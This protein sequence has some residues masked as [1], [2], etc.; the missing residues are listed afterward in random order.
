MYMYMDNWNLCSIFLLFSEIGDRE[1]RIEVVKELVDQLP[2]INRRILLMLI[3][4]LHRLL[5]TC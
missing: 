5:C 1:K 2:E 3:E 4:H